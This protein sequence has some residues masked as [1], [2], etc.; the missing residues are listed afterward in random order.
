MRNPR[1]THELPT[2]RTRVTRQAAGP[3]LRDRYCIEGTRRGAAGIGSIHHRVRCPTQYGSAQT[4]PGPTFKFAA[5]NSRVTTAGPAPATPVQRLLERDATTLSSDLLPLLDFV[6]LMLALALGLVMQSMGWLS[7]P[8]TANPGALTQLG[9]SAAVL[10]P[11]ILYDKQF[12]AL[13]GMKHGFS[14]VGRFAIRFALFAVLVLVL[15]DFGQP[16]D[17]FANQTVMGGLAVALLV[18][19][20]LRLALSRYIRHLR[21][22]GRLTQHVAVVG[23]GP[24]GDRLV[25]VLLRNHTDTVQ[26]VGIFDD[27]DTGRSAPSIKPIGNLDDLIEL[28]QRQR[29]DW[30]LL[31][32]PVG[33]EPR[34]SAITQRLSIL[35]VPIALCPQDLDLDLP[36]GSTAL[37]A[38]Q[39][40]MSVLADRPLR[41]WDVMLKGGVDLVIGGLLTLI[42]LPLLLLIAAVVKFDSP[43]PALFRQRRHAV[44]GQEFDIFKFR[45]MRWVAKPQGNTLEQTARHDKRVTSVGRFLRATSLDELPQLFNVLRGEMSLVGP[46]PHAVNMRTEDRL[47]SE[48][49]ETYAHR[50]RVKPG[51]TGWAQING[52]RGA[53]D[54]TSQLKRRVELDLQY[55][56]NWSFLLDLRILVRTFKEVVRSTDAY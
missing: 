5:M 10:A 47:G 40:P 19:G 55:I 36:L 21:R 46:R 7:L 4:L 16:L 13:A 51:I 8:H 14:W 9:L 45:T 50:H 32:L 49:T 52:A 42:L 25:Q 53:T 3:I 38:D 20:S 33:A 37:L 12:G 31:T 44:N 56:D 34:L 6:G 22:C 43:G 23:A 29:V 17:N 41:R 28:G 26:F 48:I 35:Q 54:T 2:T 15:W 1:Q 39:H 27:R 24:V 11:F 30:I 18:S